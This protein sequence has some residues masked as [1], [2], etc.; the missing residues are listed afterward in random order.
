VSSI[1]TDFLVLNEMEEMM[2]SAD[3]LHHRFGS[4][5]MVGFCSRVI[6]LVLWDGTFGCDATAF[7]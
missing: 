4:L 7:A 3:E 5:C 1:G 2:S 6:W